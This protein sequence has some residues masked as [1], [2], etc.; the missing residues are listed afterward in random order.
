MREP[1]LAKAV[2]RIVARIGI[3]LLCVGERGIHLEQGVAIG[4]GGRRGLGRDCRTGARAI[5]DNNA[6]VET[7]RQALADQ[8]AQRVGRRADA[9]RQ[10]Q[11]DRLC[12]IRL[13]GSAAHRHD[14]ADQGE[15]RRQSQSG[16]SGTQA[17]SGAVGAAVDFIAKLQSRKPV[18]LRLDMAPELSKRK[19]P[20]YYACVTFFQDDRRMAL[21]DRVIH[22]LKLRDL[23]LLNAVVQLKSIAKA[24]AQLNI[25]APA[26]SK[27]IS[28]LEHTVG[29][30]LLDRSRQGIEPTPHGRVLMERSRSRFR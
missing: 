22:R 2:D 7:C 10:D 15:R 27:A 20:I 19:V 13:S 16:R 28:E 26:V 5:F 11:L 6:L 17:T 21:I 30:R 1:R 8:T 29:V 25:T 14:A 24:A 12:R 23:R 18:E 9:K 3:E 4:R